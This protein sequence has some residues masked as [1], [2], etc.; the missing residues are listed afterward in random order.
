VKGADNPGDLRRKRE[1]AE[2]GTH[3]VSADSQWI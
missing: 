1:A 2:S 3:G